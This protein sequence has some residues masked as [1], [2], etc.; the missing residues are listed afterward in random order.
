MS[1]VDKIKRCSGNIIIWAIRS[2]LINTNLRKLLNPVLYTGLTNPFWDFICSRSWKWEHAQYWLGDWVDV[3][4]RCNLVHK[5]CGLWYDE[6]IIKGARPAPHPTSSE[7]VRLALWAF[8]FNHVEDPVW[9]LVSSTIW[10]KTASNTSWDIIY[11]PQN[12]IA[13]PCNYLNCNHDTSMK[14]LYEF[15]ILHRT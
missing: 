7:D 12:K 1:S 9:F 11:F 5:K 8:F 13:R 15:C 3:G 2:V 4:L 6:G 14:F 10:R